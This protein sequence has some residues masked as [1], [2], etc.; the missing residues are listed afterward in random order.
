MTAMTEE[1]VLFWVHCLAHNF[2]Y[3]CY[4]S[5][6]HAADEALCRE[7]EARFSRIADIY[8]DF[9]DVDIWP[10][11]GLDDPRWKDWFSKHKHLFM[12][13]IQQLAP[14]INVSM[15]E[16][17]N[18]VLSIPLQPTLD[19]TLDAVRDHLL[20]VYRTRATPVVTEPKYKL[21][22]KSNGNV[23]V[24]YEQVRQAVHMSKGTYMYGADGEQE[25]GVHETM[26]EFLKHEVDALGWTLDPRARDRLMKEDY[27]SPTSFENFKARINKLRRDMK[28]LA[29]NTIRG[30]FPS[31]EPYDSNVIDQ[32]TGE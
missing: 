4:C 32:F 19:A 17:G 2:D 21:N 27:L 7:Y 29:Q 18:V 14:P 26:I 22:R 23:A 13:N 24:G 30:M 16:T 5:A 31:T 10:P 3:S 8:D 20:G 25:L 12:P 15:L 6:R 1:W 11:K 9:G 28:A